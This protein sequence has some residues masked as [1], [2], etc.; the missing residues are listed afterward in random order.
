[1]ASGLVILPLQWNLFH[2]CQNT[3][4]NKGGTNKVMAHVPKCHKVYWKYQLGK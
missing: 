1:V 4:Q 2:L 3:K